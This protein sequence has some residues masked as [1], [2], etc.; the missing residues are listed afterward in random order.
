MPVVPPGLL[1]HQGMPGPI[2]P[3]AGISPGWEI[4]AVR[5]DARDC[6]V[7]C[8]GAGDQPRCPWITGAGR[9]R[10]IVIEYMTSGSRLAE[11]WWQLS[12]APGMPCPA[13]G[14]SIA[15]RP[16]HGEDRPGH[17]D[18]GPG[19][20]APLPAPVAGALLRTHAL[21]PRENAV[22][23]LLGL[24]HDNRS[25]GHLL[26]VSERTVKRH[27]TAILAKLH[28]ESRLQAGLTA[29]VISGLPA[30]LSWPKGGIDHTDTAWN[31]YYWLPILGPAISS[32]SGQDNRMTPVQ[33]GGT[34]AFDA[35][36]ALR[37]AGN[38][39]D[40]V[41]P[42]QRAVLAQLT[43]AEVAVLNSVKERLDAVSDAEV[44]V[45]AHSIPVKIV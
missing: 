42:A 28:L 41:T 25:I 21:S 23:R 18:S 45:E 1:P 5:P 19:R 31:T 16:G 9:E 29:L 27:I 17:G 33:G 6:R 12:L 26:G 15:D 7:G 20:P 4:W 24:G 8:Y 13:C 40:L 11:P 2:V 10:E 14:A 35:L 38:P 30:D 22:F 32:E 37:E 3:A 34:M 43:E 36:A 39:V 44:E